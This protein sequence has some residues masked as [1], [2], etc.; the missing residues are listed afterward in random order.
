[1]SGT[2][3]QQQIADL[4]MQLQQAQ[5][6]QAQVGAT[7]QAANEEAM[8]A[9]DD[10][11]Q[12]AQMAAN[13]RLGYQKI[14]EQILQLASQD[15]EMM[16]SLPTALPPGS[17]QGMAPGMAEGMGVGQPAAAAQAVMP[18]EVPAEEGGPGMPG[19]TKPS[20]GQSGS[21]SANPTATPGSTK[22]GAA[23]SFDLLK[24]NAGALAGGALGAVAGARKALGKADELPDR[25]AALEGATQAH[26]GSFASA[27][28]V[29]KARAGVAESEA[30]AEHPISTALKG[31]LKG[32]AMGAAGGAMAQ[33]LAGNLGQLFQ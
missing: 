13:M 4:Q 31:G 6:Q 25:A 14:R 20:D 29:A 9:R 18:G 1:M 3:T 16:T 8:A 17:G 23:S 30:A 24:N 7:I 12:H 28:N 5:E 26:D 22:I 33:R 19:A 27:L 11:M 2:A 32:G 10:A 21:S 15:P